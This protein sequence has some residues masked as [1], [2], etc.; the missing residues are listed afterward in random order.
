MNE[1]Q[2]FLRAIIDEPDDDAVR[3]IYAD[4][5]DEHGDTDA[6]RARAAFIRLQVEAARLDEHDPRRLDLES[7][8]EALLIA[9]RDAWLAGLERWAVNHHPTSFARG[10]PFVVRAGVCELLDRGAE[11]WAAAPFRHL[12]LWS[13]WR[14]EAADEARFGELARCA[15]LAHVRHLNLWSLPSS[16]AALAGLLASPHLAGL[17]SLGLTPPSD[18]PW[19]QAL[20]ASPLR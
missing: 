19:L 11:L 17:E 3:L 16:T 20:L 5:L 14:Q 12:S 7:Q 6:D 1:R 18:Q 4:W 15:H 8:A 13:E 9:H 2:A 10:F